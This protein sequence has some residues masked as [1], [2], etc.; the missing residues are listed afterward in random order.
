MNGSGR[1]PTTRGRRFAGRRSAPPTAVGAIVAAAVATAA[2]GVA[3]PD[4][5][6]A[7]KQPRSEARAPA[8]VQLCIK[9]TR[10]AKGSVRIAMATSV[11]RRGWKRLLIARLG[12]PG[13]QGSVGAP[14]DRGATGADGEQGPPGLQGP[15]GAPGADGQAGLP[16]IQGPQ[17]EVGSA[18][19]EGSAGQQGPA[20]PQGEIGPQ[21]DAGP[22]GSAGPEGLQGSQGDPG[23][24]GPQGETGPQGPPGTQLWAVVSSSGALV[25]GSGVTS[26]AGPSSSVFTVTF[27]QSVAS[28]AYTATPAETGTAAPGSEPLGFAVPTGLAGNANA[29]RVKTYDKGGSPIN[30]QFHLVVTC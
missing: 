20:G 11:C 25:R 18:G 14:G 19:P 5:T 26:V 30:R 22:E 10:P 4:L 13:P 27:G 7:G 1:P 2:V 29:V 21:G 12:R 15:I 24:Q 3:G 9:R 6:W 17:G 16:G 28:C 8:D 23:P